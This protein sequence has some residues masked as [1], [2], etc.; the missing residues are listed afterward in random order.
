[1]QM[2]HTGLPVS[3][4]IF[5]TIGAVRLSLPG[6]VSFIFLTRQYSFLFVPQIDYPIYT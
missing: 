3:W 6:K 1:M 4:L 5:I 2:Q